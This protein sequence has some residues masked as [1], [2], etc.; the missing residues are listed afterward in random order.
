[1]NFLALNG[2]S[3]GMTVVFTVF[4]GILVVFLGMTVIILCLFSIGKIF[5]KI[6]S[7]QTAKI[8]VK[9]TEEKIISS[10]NDDID[11]KTRVAIISAI[12]MYYLQQDSGCEFVVKKIKRI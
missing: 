1:M 8:N 10:D 6:N 2:L 4:M 12:Y 9:Q 7:K 3:D 5:D 11:E